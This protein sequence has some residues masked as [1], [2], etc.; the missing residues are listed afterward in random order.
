MI[1]YAQPTKAI[2]VYPSY[3]TFRLVALTTAHLFQHSAQL[4]CVVTR[5]KEFPARRQELWWRNRI[6]ER[7]WAPVTTA[8]LK[9]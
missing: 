4:R 9:L 5:K 3:N 6:A 1:D 8:V 7:Q 2:S